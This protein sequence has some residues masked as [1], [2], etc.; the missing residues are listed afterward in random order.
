MEV[1]EGYFSKARVEINYMK[2]IACPDF[3][4]DTFEIE[5]FIEIEKS[6]EA[7]PKG[8]Y[9]EYRLINHLIDSEISQN[10]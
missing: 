1:E 4:D 2:Q 6:G 8:K 5:N 10:Y 7:T 3:E 9:K